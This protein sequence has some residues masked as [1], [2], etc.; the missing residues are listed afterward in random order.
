M[1]LLR[2]GEGIHQIGSRP[3]GAD[4]CMSRGRMVPEK[5][6]FY[7]SEIPKLVEDPSRPLIGVKQ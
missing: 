2:S 5:L 3:M 4:F 1:M 7:L 6:L